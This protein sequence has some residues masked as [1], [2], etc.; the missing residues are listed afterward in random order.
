M[1]LELRAR[2]DGRKR[3][4]KAAP[5]PAPAPPTTPSEK[6]VMTENGE[7]EQRRVKIPQ[8]GNLGPCT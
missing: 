1:G 2:E 5:A 3:P 8:T 6:A 7:M 4:T